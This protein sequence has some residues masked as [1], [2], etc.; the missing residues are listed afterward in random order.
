MKPYFMIVVVCTTLSFFANAQNTPSRPATDTSIKKMMDTTVKPKADTMPKPLADTA[1]LAKKTTDSLAATKATQNCYTKWYDYMI[2]H[3]AKT[4]SDG[5]HPVVISF[6]SG[7]SCHCF[8]GKIEVVAGKIKAPLYVQEE[9]GEYKTSADFGKKLDAEFVT[10]MGADLW[11]ISDGMS[12]LFR[13]SDQEY[14][15]IFFYEFANKGATAKKE[16]P[17]PEDLIKPD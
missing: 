10:S 14:G 5:M 15:R 16:A 1:A 3:G 2:S 7:E 4:V 11:K 17:S 12:A 8:M 13:T 6:K 9:N